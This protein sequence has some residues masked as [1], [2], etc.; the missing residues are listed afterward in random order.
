QQ[1]PRLPAA[2]PY[3]RRPSTPRCCRGRFRAATAHLPA[4]TAASRTLDAQRP[5]SAILRWPLSCVVI[6]VL[7]AHHRRNLP[8]GA[9]FGIL[10]HD[11][12]GGKLI[13][14]AIGFFEVFSGASSRPRFNQTLNLSFV[15]GDRCR[16]EGGP[17]G[18]WQL[19]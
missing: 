9:V 15:D 12:H 11:A 8:G 6:G 5:S 16:T 7:Q 17:F 14:D 18:R 1:K 3:S 10:H 2:L 13:A 19:K 4:E